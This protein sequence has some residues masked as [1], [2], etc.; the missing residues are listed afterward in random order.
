VVRLGSGDIGYWAGGQPAKLIASNFTSPDDIWNKLIADITLTGSIGK[1]LKDNVD[2]A[3]SSRAPSGEYDVQLDATI[4]SRA[5]LGEYDIEMARVDTTI[6]SRSSHTPADV[7][8]VTTRTLSSFGTL[9]ADIWANVART[10]T[11]GTKDTE[12]DAIKAKTDN[13]P[14]D[15]ASETNVN[16]NETKIDALQT[17]I[18]T[19]KK[20][21]ANRW[22]IT[23][24]QF[25]IY[26]DDKVTPLFTFDLK[27]DGGL[28]TEDAPKERTPI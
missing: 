17:D 9:I 5:P 11:A 16:A 15:P 21:E 10:L 1:Q 4:S 26:D 25:I 18:T 3:V 13:L 6:S 28:P 20:I 22:K 24:N 2:E 23:G 12:I 14:A 7:W 8:A 27:N 19:I